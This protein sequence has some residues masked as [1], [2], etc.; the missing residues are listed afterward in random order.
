MTNG[1]RDIV[2]FLNT[3][4][5][6]KVQLIGENGILI[7]D[8]T[9]KTRDLTINLFGDILEKSPDGKNRVIAVSDLPHNLDELPL[10][11]RPESWTKKEE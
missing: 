6:R 1:Q 3:H 4:P 10:Y 11:A 5:M 9:G 2:R 7:K 8:K